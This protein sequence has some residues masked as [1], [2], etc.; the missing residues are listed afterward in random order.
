MLTLKDKRKFGK[1]KKPK[2]RQCKKFGYSWGKEL[3][4]AFRKARAKRRDDEL[5]HRSSTVLAY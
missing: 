2:N 1:G 3:R 4:K 5:H